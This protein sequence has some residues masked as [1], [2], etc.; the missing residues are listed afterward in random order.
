MTWLQRRRERRKQQRRDRYA[1]MGTDELMDELMTCPAEDM[2]VIMRWLGVRRSCESERWMA[3]PGIRANVETGCYR[4]ETLCRTCRG[5]FA[6]G[7]PDC[8]RNAAP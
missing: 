2:F 5:T 7:Y 4:H 1:L 3:D 6:N 8:I